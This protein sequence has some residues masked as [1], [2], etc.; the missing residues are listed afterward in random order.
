M[1]VDFQQTT[2]LYVQESEDRALQRHSCENFKPTQQA[3]FR[4]NTLR[5]SHVCLPICEL[6]SVPKLSSILDM[7]D[8][9]KTCWE[10]PIFSYTD[11]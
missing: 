5:K 8:L 7:D 11:P 9:Y 3:L 10:I 4:T 6:A 2:Q 1:S